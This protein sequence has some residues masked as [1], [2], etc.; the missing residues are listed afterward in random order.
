MAI[1]LSYSFRNLGTRRFTTVLTAGGMALVTFVFAAVLM[2]AEGLE[3][4]LV[5]T[6]SPE[7]AIVLRAAA[8]TDVSSVIERA[9]ANVILVRPEVEQ[10]AEGEPVAAKEV[11]V[12][13]N[14]L[15]KDQKKPAH[16]TVRG[17]GKFS[18]QLRPQVHLIA[19]RAI[20]PGTRE[21]IAG[22]NL[23]ERIH[24]ASLGGTLRF[25]LADWK[26]VGIF[27]AGK[28]AFSSELWVDADQLMA[29][30]RR[31]AYSS[32]VMKVPGQEAFQK[33]KKGLESDP[34]LT[35][36]VKREVAFYKEQSEVMSRFIRILGVAMTV[37]FSIGAMLG[38]MVTMYT[39]VANRTREI[40]TLRALGFTQGNIL[41]AFLMESLFLGLI[42][43][44]C[45]IAVS[46]LLQ[47]LTIST[48]NWQT[49]SELAFGFKLTVAIAA[50]TMGFALIMGFFGGLFPAWRAAR[51]KIVDALRE[52]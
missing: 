7:N 20:R 32:V 50:Y 42:G 41:I 51:L 24:G 26:V 28:T 12:L 46:S 8:E 37:F 1:P 25:A 48:L 36:Q 21:V 39:A 3:Q 52:E 18:M 30:F 13:V 40:G 33:L 29:A 11:A 14:L 4:T 35:A 6:G 43:G 31:N 23:A 2:L 22:K 44:A 15:K 5:E 38:A 16:V 34:R 19:G 47:W 10:T 17:I 27:D 49:F 45:G 9:N